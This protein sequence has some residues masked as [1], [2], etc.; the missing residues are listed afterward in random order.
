[1]SV[2]SPLQYAVGS[3]AWTDGLRYS[4]RW[5]N[6]LKYVL[7]QIDE[8]ALISRALFLRGLPNLECSVSK[9]YSAGDYNV[10]RRLS[11][12]DGVSWIAR[13][14]MPA[15]DAADWEKLLETERDGD[16]SVKS[17]AERN[18]PFTLTEHER[19]AIESEVSTMRLIS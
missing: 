17:K 18:I 3:E 12:S 13:I 6:R 8:E 4:G 15:L 7:G 19:Y 2:T 14:R 11:F 16:H 10:V 5:K 1:M 9:K